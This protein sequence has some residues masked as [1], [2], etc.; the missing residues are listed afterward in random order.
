MAV[1]AAT[2]AVFAVDVPL[3]LAFT[4]ADSGTRPRPPTTTPPNGP[5]SGYGALPGPPILMP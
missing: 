3:I 2:L 1:L 5:D 4:V